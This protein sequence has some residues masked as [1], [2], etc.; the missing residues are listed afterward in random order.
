MAWKTC[1]HTDIGPSILSTEK[2]EQKPQAGSVS[3]AGDLQSSTESL[4]TRQ[5]N[6]IRL[7]CNVL[8]YISW[9]RKPLADPYQ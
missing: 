4:I 6:F 8:N 9:D 7:Y 1:A 3:V 2:R 5:D